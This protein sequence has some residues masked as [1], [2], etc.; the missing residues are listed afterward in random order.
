MTKLCL[1]FSGLNFSG[2]DSHVLLPM[3][4]AACFPSCSLL[5][6]ATK[7][8][9]SFLWKKNISNTDR[10]CL[11]VEHQTKRSNLNFFGDGL[12]VFTSIERL[13]KLLVYLSI[14]NKPAAPRKIVVLSNAALQILSNYQIKP[15]HPINYVVS[16]SW[17]NKRIDWYN[18]KVA[19]TKGIE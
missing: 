12:F 1:F 14:F 19:T 9:Y 16:N 17:S 18:C 11:C 7:C 8:L 5:D 3:I 13:F 2:I 10:Q 4:A 15:F 6:V